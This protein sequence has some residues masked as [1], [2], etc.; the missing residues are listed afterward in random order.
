MTLLV[1]TFSLLLS[2]CGNDGE[3]TDS[4]V[5][6]DLTNTKL[7]LVFW[8]GK[9][10]EIFNETCPFDVL[11][12]HSHGVVIEKNKKTNSNITGTYT[13]SGD[14]ITF[15]GLS[16]WSNI[17]GNTFKITPYSSWDEKEMICFSTIDTG[18]MGSGFYCYI[19]YNNDENGDSDNGGNNNGNSGNEGGSNNEGG[20]S[21]HHYPCKPCDETGDC[22]NCFG[23]GTDP[24][25]NKKCNTCHGTGKCQICYGKGYIIV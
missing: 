14:N 20:G 10:C 4:E 21:N 9:A 11:E 8:V 25:T 22:W 7:E 13:I 19:Y 18:S 2:S 16:N 24:I 1:T 3:P 12:F 23:S 5:V 6:L 17:W 15:N